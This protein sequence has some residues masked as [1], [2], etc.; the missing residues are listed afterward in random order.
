MTKWALLCGAMLA[1]GSVVAC[2]DDGNG[3]SAD[4]GGSSAGGNGSGGNDGIVHSLS[5]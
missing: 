2:G 1:A 5:L 4:S 3:E